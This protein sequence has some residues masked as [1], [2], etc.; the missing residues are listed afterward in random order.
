MKERI[1]TVMFKQEANKMSCEIKAKNQAS[2]NCTI[3]L[4][5][6]LDK[7]EYKNYLLVFLHDMSI[8]AV[9]IL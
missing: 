2:M 6:I 7:D 4:Y 5:C 1:N 3:S 9:D 8:A